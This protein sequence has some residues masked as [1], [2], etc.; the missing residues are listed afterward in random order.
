[1]EKFDKL[2]VVGR[3]AYG[4]VYLCRRL[5]DKKLVIIKQIPVE[6]MTKD[7]RLA[8]LN[9]VI[10]LSMLDHPNIIQYYE[11]FLED[12]ALMIVMEY[13]EGGTL[14]DYLQH[15]NGQL[16]TEEEILRFF[17]QLLLSMQHVHSKQILHRDLKTQNILLD[18][19]QEVVKISD[20][21]IS[22]VLTKSKALTVVGTPC[23]ISPELLMKSDIWALGCVLH[24]LAT[25][26]RSFEAQTLPA[27]ILKIMRGS[28]APIASHYSS[29]LKQLISSMLQLDP[30][31]RPSV[32]QIMA[33]PFLLPYLINHYCDFG[34]LPCLKL[35]GWLVGWLVASKSRSRQCL[36]QVY[37]WG[38]GYG[39][40]YCLPLPC[41]D[42]LIEE[43]SVG[44]TQK[45]AV[46][47]NGRLLLWEVRYFSCIASG[48]N[49]TPQYIPR[50]LEGQSAVF[51]KHI[52]CGDMFTACLT[53]RGILMTFGT[54]TTGCLGH[55]NYANV[56]QA[57]IVEALL[58]Y[59]VLQVSCGFS[60]VIV[61]TGDDEVFTWGRGDNGRLGL[62]NNQSHCIPQQ[63]AMPLA[64]SSGSGSKCKFRSVHAGVDGSIVVTS[65]DD[66][67][68]CGSNRHNKLGLN[69][70]LPPP[71]KS[72]TNQSRPFI[73]EVNAFTQVT[74][75]Y[76]GQIKVKDV[77]MGTSHTL[78]LS[79]SGQCCS[80]GSNQL[81]Q[82]GVPMDTNQGCAVVQF[83]KIS[84]LKIACGDAFSVLSTSDGSIWT[85]GK[86]SRGRLGRTNQNISPP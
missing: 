26:A 30:G 77:A 32:N 9:E 34:A 37:H 43:V 7:Q 27:L 8:A 20:F 17:I 40:P 5:A 84:V 24:E 58:G 44:R 50:Y 54:G 82:L 52:S 83:V 41:N 81:G 73:N 46:T 31:K 53:D 60:H 72:P 70:F 6:Q 65:T 14:F 21:G 71:S 39:K 2:R 23:Y 69:N 19:K 74:S 10:V 86:S 68:V 4:T 67:L 28:V 75:D 16:L 55:D 45:A 1:M 48:D 15:R 85:W 62:G 61:L 79:T 13:A 12:K 25:L 76:L 22:K 66:M 56:T 63:V 80:Y 49:D 78:I 18:K 36:S 35:V 33:T 29:H 47:K 11:N 3:G 51:I 64:G 38:G 59:E 42:T 57:K